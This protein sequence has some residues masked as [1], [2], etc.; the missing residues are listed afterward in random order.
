MNAKQLIVI[1]YRFNRQ[2]NAF[3]PRPPSGCL[4]LNLQN[5]W[6]YVNV[7][8][9]MDFTD[10]IKGCSSGYLKLGRVSCINSGELDLITLALKIGKRK[11]KCQWEMQQRKRKRSELKCEKVSTFPCWHWD[12]RWRIWWLRKLRIHAGSGSWEWPVD[13]SQQGNG[14]SYIC[15]ELISGKNLNVFWNTF[16]S[17]DF[18]KECMSADTFILALWERSKK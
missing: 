6:I 14:G 18:I 9:Q 11:Q 13:T 2:N 16:S 1:N 5:L 7:M 17:R 10:G 8:W 12:G 4:C 3:S 15:M